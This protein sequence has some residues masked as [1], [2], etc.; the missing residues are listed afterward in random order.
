MA[1]CSM[2]GGVLLAILFGALLHASWN[3]LVKRAPI[4]LVATAG[5]AIGAALIS[6]VALPFLPT[7]ASE[8][9][10][11]LAASVIAELLYGVLLSAAYRLGDLGL[12]YPLMRGAA[13]LLVALA[14]GPLIAEQLSRPTWAGVCLIC[15][16]IFCLIMDARSRG[17]SGPAMGLALLNA[18]VIACYT[19]IDGLGV[20]ASGSAPAYTLWIFLLTGVPWLVWLARK[21][22]PHRWGEIRRPVALSLLGGACSLGSY[23]IALWAMTRAPVAMVAAVRETSIVFGSLLGIFVLR[24][25]V[26]LG[27]AIAAAAIVIGVLVMKI[28]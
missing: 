10:P 20:R 8:S 13:P 4:K 23:G 21:N 24:E 7:P 5:V 27:R 12:T 2:T 19:V 1:A 14:S 25:R 18:A 3:A 9:W 26:T 16:G 6:A 15:G 22:R 11:Y 28:G 17:H